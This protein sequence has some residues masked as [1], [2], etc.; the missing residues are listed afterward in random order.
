MLSTPGAGPSAAAAF[1]DADQD[2]DLDLYVGN[3]VVH[4]REHPYNDGKPC[5]WKGLKVSCG[6]LGMPAGLDTFYEN[7][8]T[9]LVEA[10]KKFGFAQVEAAYALGAVTCDLDNDGDLD[11]YV[12]NDSV[13]NYLFEN[14]GGGHFLERG[15]DLGLDYSGR[16][17]PQAGMGVDVGDVDNDGRLDVFVTNFSDDYSTLYHNHLTASGVTY[18]TDDTTLANLRGPSFDHLSWGCRLTDLDRD[19]WLDLIV[20]SGHVYPQVDGA[21]LRTSYAQLNQVLRNLGPDDQGVIHFEDISSRAGPGF[22]KRAVTRGLVTVDLDNDG[23]LDLLMT[24]LDHKPT[25]LRNDSSQ[26]GAWI[27][28]QLVG[29]DK[30]PDAIGARVRVTD[31][32]GTVRLSERASGAS[33]MSSVDP[34]LL[35]GL[36][37]ARGPLRKVSVR[38]PDGQTQTHQNLAVG[39]YWTLDQA[40]GTARD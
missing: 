6:P 13:R 33:Y 1:F 36:G 26:R 19:G 24:E 27:G 8:G 17:T 14:Q 37:Q 29:R 38:W 31:S 40:T 30:L 22:E 15:L 28:F 23:D 12:V 9:H 16:G 35:L 18:F 32:L 39:R 25:L 34:R 21:G 4:D 20:V 11:L 3:Y 5:D 7:V 10:G 2:G